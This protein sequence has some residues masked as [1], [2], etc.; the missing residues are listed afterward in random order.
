MDRPNWAPADVNL[1]NP[2]TARI[3]DYFLG[4]S[5]NF[6]ADRSFAETILELVPVMVQVA[7]EHRAFLR[8]AVAWCGH[9]GIRQFLD[10]GSGIPTV[11]NVHEVAQAVDPSCRVAYV[12]L[13][14]V[15]VAHSRAILSSNPNTGIVAGDLRDPEAVLT[16][17]V[18]RG[19]IDFTEPVAILLVSVLH[20]LDDAQRPADLVAAYARAMVPGSYLVISHAGVDREFTQREREALVVYG[21]SPSPIYPRTSAEV[22]GL[23]GD[24]TLVEPGV[25]PVTRWRPDPGI[26]QGRGDVEIPGFSGVGRKG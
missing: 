5:H 12:D 3:W 14:P 18:T 24:L 19:L 7:H 9:A 21:E 15:A 10:L 13:D 11:G 16:D 26:A 22:A 6:A 4:G 23:F 17:P 25:V 8:R 2:S 1:D 20:F